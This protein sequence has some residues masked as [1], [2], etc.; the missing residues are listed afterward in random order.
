LFKRLPKRG[1]NNKRH[2]EDM[3]PI[4]LGT[5]QDYIDMGRLPESK[6][7]GSPLTMK[8]LLDAGV[9]GSRFSQIK[10]HGMKLLAKGKERLRSPINIHVSRASQSAIEALEAA[11][12]SVTAVHYNRLALRVLMKPDKFEGK[13]IPKQAK[14]PPKRL[15]YYTSYDN[16]GYLSLEKQLENKLN[17]N[18]K[19]IIASA[20]A[21]L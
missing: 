18:A 10:H 13:L 3:I 21:D 14:P 8:D 7:D 2:G 11:G 9:C 19:D 4:N 12:G 15:P 17:L 20:S 1:F 16:R 5:L 6:P